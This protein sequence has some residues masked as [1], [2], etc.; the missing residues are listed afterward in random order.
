MSS[1]DPMFE[2]ARALDVRLMAVPKRAQ[3]LI[4]AL[5][6]V[7]M[8]GMSIS[9]VPREYADY[10][11]IPLLRR[12]HQNQHYGTDTISDMYVSKVI[13]ND[14]RDMYTKSELSQ[15]PLEAATWSKAESAPYPAAALVTEAGLYA[16]GEWTGVG[17]YGMIL[18]L[19]CAFLALSAWYF[20]QTRWYLFP[21]LYLNF[22][23]LSNRFV[24]VQDDTYIIM[25]VV[26]M[27][28][29]VLARYRFEAS[30][31]LMA[32][33]IAMKLS[34]LYYARH[35]ST[36]TGRMA[37]LSVAIL[38]AG[39]VLPY[40]VWDNYLYIYGFHDAVKGNVY[41]TAAALVVGVPFTTLLWYI[42]TKLGF[43]LEDRIGWSLV[44][45]AMFIA[46]KMRVTTHLLIA[47]L[48]P[49]KRGFRNIAAAVGMG[50]HGAFPSLVL[51]GSAGSIMTVL[52]F[53]AQH[54]YLEQIGFDTVRDDFRH[55]V[56]TLKMMLTT[57]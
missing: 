45:F 10:S 11:K 55:P 23:Y 13:L 50:F 56:R 40:F 14:P 37:A 53:V 26:V 9:N 16:I 29:L 31:A 17:F 57:G 19:A 52:L 4:L 38:V 42:E 12:L 32:V 49:D 22:S 6:A 39:F 8:I 21:V 33:A 5:T 30:H 48:V 2:R 47:L 35:I 3:Y 24:Y 1:I 51:L 44:P 7:V 25:L 34:P 27:A 46:I 15:T 54:H 28:A 20:L 41:D 36:M 18:G 43:D